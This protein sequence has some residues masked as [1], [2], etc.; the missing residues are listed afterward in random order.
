MKITLERLREIITEEVIKEELA[1]E[2]AAPAIAAMLQGMKAETTSDVFGD[3]FTHMYGEEAL[4]A[5]ADKIYADDEASQE[6]FPTEYQPG[7]GEGDRPVMGFKEGVSDIIQEEYYLYKIEQYI[8]TELL[9]E[10]RG[11]SI[12]D[13]EEIM[14]KL[15]ADPNDPTVSRE[16]AW[17]AKMTVR[18]YEQGDYVDPQE[19]RQQALATTRDVVTSPMRRTTAQIKQLEDMWRQYKGDIRSAIEKI[20]ADNN[21][22][23]TIVDALASFYNY[24]T[25]AGNIQQ[26][27]VS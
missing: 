6:G 12:E 25:S 15:E 3:V 21:E 18:E 2:I 27:D 10:V 4:E 23:Q 17:D 16:D 8:S 14:G 5:E 26:H 22:E 9:T 11:M 13:A 1:P 20:Q 24:L 19:L 7:G